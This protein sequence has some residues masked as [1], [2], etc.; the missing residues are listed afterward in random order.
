M[1]GRE[2]REIW[3][4]GI[5]DMEGGEGNVPEGST[6]AA[7]EAEAGDVPDGVFDGEEGGG[8]VD[9]RHVPRDD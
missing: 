5:V 9:E 8:S 7:R 2:E 6:V 1:L 4:W 3:H